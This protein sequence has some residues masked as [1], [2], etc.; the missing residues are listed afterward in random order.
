MVNILIIEL[1]HEVPRATNLNEINTF[2]KWVKKK[3]KENKRTTGLDKKCS[4]G[5]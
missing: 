4:V 3:V 5:W 1:I 2:D